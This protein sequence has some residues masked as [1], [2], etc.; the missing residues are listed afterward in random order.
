MERLTRVRFTN[1]DKVMYPGLGVTKAQVIEH[2]IRMAPRMLGFLR[3]R[4]VVTTRFPDGIEGKGFYEK[5]APRGTPEWVETFRRYSETADRE[6]NHI[7]CN[8]LDT[9]LWLA[10][11]AALEIHVTLSKAETYEEPDIVLFDID[12]EPPAGFS[13]AVRVALSLEEELDALG[14]EA[15]VKTSGKKG[16]H[17]AM[18][19]ESGYK[20]SQTREFVHEFGRHL[21][22]EDAM[23]VSE[24]S[25]SKEPGKVYIDYLQNS[26]GRTMICPYSLRAEEG[27]P[28]STPLEWGELKG[29]DPKRLNIFSVSKRRMDPW[30][31]FWKERHR[32]EV[33]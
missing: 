18:P 12:P 26:S 9:L 31:S 25:R 17:V 22:R 13:E 4:V 7:L 2:Y 6:I 27:A 15:F 28:V 29:L 14:F 5:D 11:L 33:G 20:F 3:G 24:R 1:L 8:D 10:N 21:A 16:L 30:D 32:L 23:V 19:M